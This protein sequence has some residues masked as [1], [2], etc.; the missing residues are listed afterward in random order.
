MTIN[1]PA[2]KKTAITLAVIALLFTMVSIWPATGGYVLLT[3]IIGVFVLMI[4]GMFSMYEETKRWT[5]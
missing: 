5:K 3:I 1:K 2:A 4:Y